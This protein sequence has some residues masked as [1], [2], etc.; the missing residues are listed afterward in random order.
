ML[1]RKFDWV[2]TDIKMA[3]WIRVKKIVRFVLFSEDS[4]S[5]EFEVERNR[6]ANEEKLKEVKQM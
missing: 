6:R 4:G 2:D 3:D 5:L 1:P